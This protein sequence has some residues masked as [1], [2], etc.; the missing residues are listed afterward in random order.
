MLSIIDLRTTLSST[1]ERELVRPEATISFD[2]Q[3]YDIA[4]VSAVWS[5]KSPTP[6]IT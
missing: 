4:N 5:Q 6:Q 3:T 2:R 1:A